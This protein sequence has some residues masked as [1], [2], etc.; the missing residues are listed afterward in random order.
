MKSIAIIIPIVNNFGGAVQALQSV[1]TK[2]SWTPII[3]PQW[4]EPKP[5]SAAWNKGID[6]AFNE[7]SFDY[8]LVINDDII[9]APCTIDNLVTEFE[10]QSEDVL[11][12]TGSNT[13]IDIDE[14]YGTPLGAFGYPDPGI[15]GNFREHPDFSCFM[16]DRR[17]PE[18]VGKFD[19]NF[20][21]AYFEDNDMHYRIQLAGC[22]AGCTYSAP[23]YHFG[24]QTAKPESFHETF[25]A[26]REYYVRKWG[27][28]PG[29][30]TFAKPFNDVS[31]T[32][33]DF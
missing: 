24:S 29:Q 25:R 8:A 12:L 10:N 22:K 27:A 31:K 17:L 16:I 20:I 32:W 6:E 11:M 26:N 4:R 13:R 19:E 2:H 5:L 15:T 9:F 18:I 33:K 3:L 14:K 30:E 23:Y 28:A 7:K 21:P 1:N